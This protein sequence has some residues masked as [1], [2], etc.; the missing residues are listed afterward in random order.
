MSIA[1]AGWQGDAPRWGLQSRMKASAPE[2]TQTLRNGFAAYGAG[3]AEHWKPSL[4]VYEHAGVLVESRRQPDPPEAR[5]TVGEPFAGTDWGVGGNLKQGKRPIQP[6]TAL[7]YSRGGRRYIPEQ[8]GKSA[9]YSIEQ[10]L[11]R[12]TLVLRKDGQRASLARSGTFTIEDQVGVRRRVPQRFSPSDLARGADV[13]AGSQQTEHVVYSDGF[14]RREGVTPSLV[15]G[16]RRYAPSAQ[17]GAQLRERPK[18]LSFKERSAAEV[19]RE[20]CDLVGALDIAFDED[21]CSPRPAQPEPEPDTAAEAQLPPPPPAK[22]PA[23][24]KK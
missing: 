23:A 11:A 5:S 21:A 20:E 8:T 10:E 19:K 16:R 2:G 24:R 7:D 14:F 13:P 3:P 1:A 6:G 12:K 15:L 22:A 9:H 18:G 17:G 4:R